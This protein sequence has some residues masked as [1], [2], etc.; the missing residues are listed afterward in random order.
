MCLYPDGAPLSVT[1]AAVLNCAYHI[2]TSGSPSAGGLSESKIG[3]TQTPATNVASITGMQRN[4]VETQ[5][6][7]GQEL[8]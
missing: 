7:C 6:T 2:L 3:R 1:S 8:G 5:D 4:A